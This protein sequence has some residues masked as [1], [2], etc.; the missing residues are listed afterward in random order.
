MI[1]NHLSPGAHHHWKTAGQTAFIPHITLTQTQG[2][3]LEFHRRQFPARLAF[4]MT[5]NNHKPSLSTVGLD[6][7]YPVFSHGQFYV[8]VSRGTHLAQDQ[9]FYLKG[10]LLI[11]LFFLMS[12]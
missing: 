9:G 6:L 11:T 5:I 1:S 8:A 4:G 2:L 10:M 12:Y 3:S 7:R